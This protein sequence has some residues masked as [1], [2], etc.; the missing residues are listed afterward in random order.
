MSLEDRPD[1]EQLLSDVFAIIREQD[2]IHENAI[3]EKLSLQNTQA[4]KSDIS[5]VLC[6]LEGRGLV[7][8]FTKH[9]ENEKRPPRKAPSVEFYYRARTP[10]SETQPQEAEKKSSGFLRRWLG[11]D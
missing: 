2:E 7:E 1:R 11:L 4:V 9:V 5:I 8:H 3:L 6:M 10:Q